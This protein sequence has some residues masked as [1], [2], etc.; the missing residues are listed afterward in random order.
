MIESKKC[1]IANYV[2]SASDLS[3]LILYIELG[4]E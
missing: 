1:L 3:F 2:M 4:E